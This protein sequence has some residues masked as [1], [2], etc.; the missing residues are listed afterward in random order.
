MKKK[1]EIIYINGV[2]CVVLEDGDIIG[3]KELEMIERAE[4]KRL[5]TPIIKRFY[6]CVAYHISKVFYEI[7]DR[8]FYVFSKKHRD[9]M[10]E[11]QK[12]L[13]TLKNKS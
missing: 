9:Y 13:D 6:N 7:R 2:K 1:R 11:L 4:Q 10:K 3:G 5:E 12:E 8:L